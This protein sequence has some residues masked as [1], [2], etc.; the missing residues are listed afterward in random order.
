MTSRIL[1]LF[2]DPIANRSQV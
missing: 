2:L 1:E